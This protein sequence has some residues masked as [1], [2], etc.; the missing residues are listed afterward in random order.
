M[1]ERRTK[2]VTVTDEGRDKGKRFLITEMPASQGE[3]WAFRV[4][5]AL[6][7]NNVQVPG[8]ETGMSGLA[9]LGIKGMIRGLSGLPWFVAEPLLQEMFQCIQACPDPK[10]PSFVR[11]LE[12]AESGDYDIE[13][14]WTRVMLR[15]EIFQL[16]VD[17]SSAA[18][19]SLFGKAKEAAG[20]HSN[21]GTGSR[22]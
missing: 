8:A 20:K 15:K 4:L 10:N 13:E 6:T 3:S 22:K 12:P 19:Q 18:I 5:L 9:E 21:T 16:H 2:L 11:A 17:F 7:N 1:G 14:I